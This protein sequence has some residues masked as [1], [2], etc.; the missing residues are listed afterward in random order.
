MIFMKRV[1]IYARQAEPD[2]DTLYALRQAVGNRGDTVVA[3]F[4][5]NAE[6][7]GRGKYSGWRGLLARLDEVDEVLVTNVGDLPGRNVAD[8]LKILETLRDHQV[9]LFVHGGG[10]DTGSTSFATLEIVQK[11]RAAKLSQAIKNGQARALAA[12][13]R[14]GRPE[15]PPRIRQQIMA[16]I[17]A[18]H[19]VRPVARQYSVSPAFVVNLKRKMA[20]NTRTEPA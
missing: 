10:S 20:A 8:L 18:N 14:I 2:A 12:G 6:I 16:A 5:D 1:A 3:E 9:T 15:V 19:G 11:Y 4:V 17:G 13:K 7:T